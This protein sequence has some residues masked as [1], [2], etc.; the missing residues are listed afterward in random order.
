MPTHTMASQNE[1]RKFGKVKPPSIKEFL[2][3]KNSGN[4]VII[5]T[6]VTVFHFFAVATGK[7]LSQSFLKA[8]IPTMNS[9]IYSG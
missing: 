6:T 7:V 1:R 5:V 4:K 2:N 3:I 8:R 9:R